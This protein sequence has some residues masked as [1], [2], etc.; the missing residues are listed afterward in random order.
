MWYVDTSMCGRCGKVHV[1][2]TVV[3]PHFGPGSG[4]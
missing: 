2:V 4:V 1:C 3:L